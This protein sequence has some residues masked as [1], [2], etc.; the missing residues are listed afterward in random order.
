MTAVLS[1][2]DAAE[3]EEEE[4]AP[5]GMASLEEEEP[6]PEAF[7]YSQV[8]FNRFQGGSKQAKARYHKGKDRGGGGGKFGRGKASVMRQCL[9]GCVVQGQKLLSTVIPGELLK[10][11]VI[12]KI[13]TEQ[14][15]FF[16][17]KLI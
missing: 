6:Q 3:N 2:H 11:T 1:R 8:D 13:K 4:A 12:W 14:R 17:L 16:C 5:E 9:I 10:L 15:R 7:D